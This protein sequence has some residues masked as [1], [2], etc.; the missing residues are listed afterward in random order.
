MRALDFESGQG[1]QHTDSLRARLELGA[2]RSYPNVTRPTTDRKPTGR[3]KP[4][5][6][7]NPNPKPL[8]P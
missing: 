5:T 2:Q 8:N 4:K 7:L 6:L 3:F 1:V